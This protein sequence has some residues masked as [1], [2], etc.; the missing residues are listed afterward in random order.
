MQGAD[1][2]SQANMDAYLKFTPSTPE[3]IKSGGA[4]VFDPNMAIPTAGLADIERVHRENGRT[5]YEKPLDMAKA[6]DER[7]AN[8]AIETLGKAAP[9][10]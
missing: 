2:L 6:I 8:K 9:A 5:E 1:Y 4:I 3:A 7:F 10:K